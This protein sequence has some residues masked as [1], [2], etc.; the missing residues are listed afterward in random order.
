M[1]TNR[2]T[3]MILF[4]MLLI[5]LMTLSSC[6]DE[7]DYG[8]VG[9]AVETAESVDTEGNAVDSMFHAQPTALPY[10]WK[11]FDNGR[12]HIRMPYP[13]GWSAEMDAD[14]VIR[15]AAPKD[16][17]IF[18]GMTLYF[19]STLE[20]TEIRTS[21]DIANLV[22]PLDSHI[23]YRYDGTKIKPDI[24]A[25]YDDVVVNKKISDPN[26]QLQKA[27]RDW[28]LMTTSGIDDTYYMQK[29][30]FLWYQIP[31]TLSAVCLND[32]ADQLNDLMTYMFSNSKYIANSFG[33]IEM[34]TVFRD[35]GMTIPMSGIYERL[36]ADPGD[37]FDGAV[38]YTCPAGSGTCYSQ[39]CL[40]IYETSADKLHS[41]EGAFV[42]TFETR[43]LPTITKTVFG[44][45]PKQMDMQGYMASTD[46]HVTFNDQETP[47]Y[48]YHFSIG[49]Y[50]TKLPPHTFIYQNWDMAIY[51]I[52]HGDYVDIVVLTAPQDV[53]ESAFDL[54]KLM[55]VKLEYKK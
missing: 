36:D 23:T 1:K 8:E 44:V 12:A 25:T 9:N 54:I 30:S 16:D 52:E 29:T 51:P 14:Y 35:S 43:Y 6:K 48:I 53:I 22:N 39:S 26:L 3:V 32:N 10:K 15:F 38:T 40:S 4:C 19:V 27:Y 34:D 55:S 45:S 33:K 13:D 11:T 24:A 50:A 18:P 49:Y 28:N 17:K 37:I 47:E 41:A 2:I 31:C 21:D 46:G 7:D 5:P 42:D 20:K